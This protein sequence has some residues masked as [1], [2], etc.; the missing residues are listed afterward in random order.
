MD[1][2]YDNLEWINA[3]QVGK[4]E[5]RPLAPPKVDKEI[6]AIVGKMIYVN[7]RRIMKLV[8]K[9]K[10]AKDDPE[11]P[12]EFLKDGAKITELKRVFNPERFGL[13]PLQL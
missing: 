11:A 10:K 3:R 2:N 9:W 7:D 13:E 1:D 5:I 4:A 12:D 6:S 8:T